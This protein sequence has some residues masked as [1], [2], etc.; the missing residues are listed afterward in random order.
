MKNT[1]LPFLQT[2]S[3]LDRILAHKWEELQ[4]KRSQAPLREIRAA[5][6]SLP[7]S[8]D[9]V[10]QLQKSEC[11]AII[12]E[13][14]R[15]SPSAGTIQ[16]DFDAVQLA[17]KYQALGATAVSVLTDREFFGGSLSDLQKVRKKIALP[18]LRKD[19]IFDPYQLYES[20]LSGADAILLI[21]AA[22]ERE[23]LQDLLQ[24]TS[25]L[26]CTAL[27]EVHEESELELALRCGTRLIG[28]NN[29]DLRS[30]QTDLNT[31]IRLAPL[32]PEHTTWVAE[33]G[34]RRKQDVEA[35]AAAGADAVLVGESLVRSTN[36]PELLPSFASVPRP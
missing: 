11:V 33:S 7:P 19:F 14:K 6:E 9:F 2:D 3:I 34:I 1:H 31:S 12:A 22:L 20:R 18:L 8:R 30:F 17:Q 32:I 15:A 23:L 29:R 35:M 10:G 13:C 36:L 24:L 21:V 27:V 5:A 25:E 16:P 28:I 4:Q 26:H